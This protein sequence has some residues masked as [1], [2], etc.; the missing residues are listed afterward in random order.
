MTAYSYEIGKLETMTGT[1]AVSASSSAVSGSGTAFLTEFQAGDY[2]LIAGQ[3]RIVQT[4]TNDTSLAV[5][6]DF[7]TAASGQAIYRVRLRNVETLVAGMPAP[8]GFFQFYSV[9]LPLEDGGVRG[10]GWRKAMWRWQ[11]LTQAQRD[12]L[13][14]YCTGASADVYIKTRTV[15]NS[16]AYV[17]YSAK[18][19]WPGPDP[20]QRDALRRIEFEL[21]FQAL[22]VW[23]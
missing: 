23:P 12:A 3:T 4:V 9:A 5:T 13:R 22:V 7:L 20:E 17:I 11:F 21:N 2:I 18:M 6:A 10:G 16:D 15:D 19:I 8:K 14:T 1:G